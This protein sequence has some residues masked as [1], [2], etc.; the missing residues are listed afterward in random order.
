MSVTERRIFILS[1]AT[2]DTASRVVRAALKQFV[3]D[4]QIQLRRFPNVVRSSEVRA[5]LSEA[6][7][8]PTLVVHTFAAGPLRKIM[9]QEAEK[10][11]IETLDL[12][13]RCSEPSATS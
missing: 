7:L 3:D 13:G 8:G 10:L 5:I 9:D 1:D 11:G 4:E 6:K 2:G 12:L